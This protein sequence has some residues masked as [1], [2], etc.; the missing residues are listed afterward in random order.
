MNEHIHTYIQV[1]KMCKSMNLY[2][3]IHLWLHRWEWGAGRSHSITITMVNAAG[4]LR[5]VPASV[6]REQR[7]PGEGTE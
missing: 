4:G 6:N 2:T 5:G 3:G 1:C 7:A